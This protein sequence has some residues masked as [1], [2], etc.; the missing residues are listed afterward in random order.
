MIVGKKAAGSKAKP[1]FVHFV[2]EPLWRVYEAALQGNEGQEMLEKVI[3]SMNLTIPPRDLQ[4]KDLK[5]VRQAVMSRLLPLSDTVLS[6]V[7]DCLP[8]PILAQSDRIS[9]LLPK[10]EVLIDVNNDALVELDHV[11]RAVGGCDSTASAPCVAFVSKMF[12]VPISVLPLKETP[13]RGKST[14]PVYDDGKRDRACCHRLNRSI[15]EVSVSGRGEHVLVATG[16]VMK[17]PSALTKV[18]NES[19][20][21]FQDIIEGKS[22][23]GKIVSVHLKKNLQGEEINQED[24]ESLGDPMLALRKHMIDAAESEIDSGSEGASKKRSEEDRKAWLSCLQ[25]ILALGARR[26]GP[27]I[28]LVPNS[29]T[30][31]RNIEG[32]GGV[33]N[34]NSVGME[35]VLVQGFSL[36][37]EELGL[38]EV[39][40][41]NSKKSAST[42]KGNGS[43][44]DSFYMEAESL[45]SSVVSG[46]QLA[47]AAGPLCDEPMWGMALLVEAYISPVRNKSPYASDFAGEN[48]VHLP[49]QYGQFSAQVMTVV[50]EACF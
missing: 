22:G 49:E 12:A 23:H 36:L 43:E 7:I 40:E 1:M 14:M 32:S 42:V 3:K 26:V 6:M 39:S 13:A 16:E 38:V 8:D 50:K 21:L 15:F 44:F 27:N 10:H 34:G 41:E 18:V 11:R 28:L 2:L 17:L 5:V 47:T 9:R 20:D 45:E 25:S 30:L 37:S 31:G 35:P 29:M 48:G 46:F 24:G 4:H 19:A 33:S